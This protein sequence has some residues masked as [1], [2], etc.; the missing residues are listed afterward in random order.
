MNTK[1]FRRRVQLPLALSG[2]CQESIDFAIN[3]FVEHGRTNQS[4]ISECVQLAGRV[5]IMR[6][7]LMA[8]PEVSSQWLMTLLADTM[9]MS[10]YLIAAI[11][12]TVEQVRCQLWG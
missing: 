4:D 12:P 6:G 8:A 10:D 5:E 11:R 9:I 7:S 1:M 3:Y 2:M